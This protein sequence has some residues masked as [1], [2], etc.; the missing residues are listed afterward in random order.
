M[1]FD[2]H[3]TAPD[4]AERPRR[5]EREVEGASAYERSTIIDRDHN[6][7]ARL[8]I[9]DTEMCSE[10]KARMCARVSGGIEFR[11]GS[12]ML[13]FRIVGSHAGETV[14]AFAGTFIASSGSDGDMLT[15]SGAGSTRRNV[16]RDRVCRLAVTGGET[17]VRFRR[18]C[19]C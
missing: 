12:N 18:A 17:L 3:D 15:M 11:P 10:W 1:G 4:H 13:T 19:A 5:A 6:A 2:A 14:S 7:A 16:A 9:G 8:R